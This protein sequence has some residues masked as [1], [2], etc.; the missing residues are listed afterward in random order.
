MTAPHHLEIEQALISELEMG[1][2]FQEKSY[3]LSMKSM[4]LV[5]DQGKHLLD[6][7]RPSIA[8]KAD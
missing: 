1:K 8:G 7:K 4:L 2:I 5:N 6:I 3:E